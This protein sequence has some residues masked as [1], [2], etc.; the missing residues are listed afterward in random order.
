MMKLW[1]RKLL[2]QNNF[3][4]FHNAD[5]RAAMPA[6][7]F[8]ILL[9][10]VSSCKKDK[11][12]IGLEVQPAGDQLNVLFIDT[13]TLITSTVKE[14]FVRSDEN[15]SNLL[16]SYV[17]PVFG[18]AS[19]SVYTQFRLITNDVNFGNPS[20]LVVDSIVVSLKY[21]GYYG[22]LD[23]QNFRIY[24]LTESIY[25]DSIY[26]SND[27]IAYDLNAVGSLL[28]HTPNVFDSVNVGGTNEA[29]QLRIPLNNTFGQKIIN[30]SGSP[31]LAN[32]DNFLSFFKGLYITTDNFQ[33]AGNGGILYLDLLSTISKLTLYYTDTTTQTTH[34]HNFVINENSARINHFQHDYT[35]TPVG[36]QLSDPSSGLEKVYVQ[37]MAGVKAKISLPYLKNY[38]GNASI[39]INKAEL[40][41][42]VE[43]DAGAS[44][45]APHEKLFVV[46]LDSSGENTVIIDQLEGETYYNGN[47]DSSTKEYR[48]NIG[49]HIHAV[50]KGE[51]TDY[52]FYIVASGSAVNANRVILKG[53]GNPVKKM[54]LQLTYTNI[55]N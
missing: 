38:A 22:N 49:R 8:I 15:I 6:I 21:K 50:L 31:N 18:Y 1:N 33:A 16:G 37:S 48:F 32:N 20:K 2:W 25:K 19:S 43:D 39:A 55:L 9:F 52:G 41:L 42:P 5:L 12:I 7:F 35:G 11:D 44:V 40:I 23:P 17:D 3:K 46:A 4:S 28:N 54:K 53:G 30:E 47:Y 51:R 26:Y 29:P 14:D 34:S 10:L 13:S 45:F 27:S 24:E 36:T